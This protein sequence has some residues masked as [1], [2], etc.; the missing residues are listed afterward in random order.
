MVAGLGKRGSEMQGQSSVK[1]RDCG[2]HDD[3]VFF[4][5]NSSSCRRPILF[6]FVFGVFAKEYAY[7]KEKTWNLKKCSRLRKPEI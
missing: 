1:Q 5:L 3:S 6:G 7:T 4:K 2:Q